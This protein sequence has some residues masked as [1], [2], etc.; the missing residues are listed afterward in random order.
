MA[1]SE[2]HSAQC[3]GCD[4]FLKF[5]PNRHGTNQ[6]RQPLL[7]RTRLIR[8]QALLVPC[9]AWPVFFPVGSPKSGYHRE[10]HFLLCV[11]EE[12]TS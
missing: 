5:F 3:L 9:I 10:P 8:K 6:L 11:G 2:E 12:T 4:R 1:M 7:L